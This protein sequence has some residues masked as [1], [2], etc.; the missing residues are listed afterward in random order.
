MQNSKPGTALS[1]FLMGI[2]EIQLAAL[3]KETGVRR[4]E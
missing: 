2:E 4:K 1:T 3:K